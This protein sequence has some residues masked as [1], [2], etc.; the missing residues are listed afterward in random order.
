MTYTSVGSNLGRTKPNHCAWVIFLCTSEAFLGLLFAGMCA[1]I[2]FGKVNRVQSHANIIFSNA[3]CLQYEEID[4]DVDLER[5]ESIGDLLSLTAVPVVHHA[6]PNPDPDPLLRD[7]ENQLEV[8]S[9][10]TAS[11]RK[12]KAVVNTVS[13]GGSFVSGSNLN[14]F[15]SSLIFIYV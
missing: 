5:S 6:V 8:K 3:V 1:A 12:F 2:L 4:D 15:S 10:K 7:E 9:P 14:S 13:W 11:M